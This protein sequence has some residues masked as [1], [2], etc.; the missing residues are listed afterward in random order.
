MRAI[1]TLCM[2]FSLAVSVR[3]QTDQRTIT[4]YSETVP[5]E[6]QNEYIKVLVNGLRD[7]GFSLYSDRAIQLDRGE[8]KEVVKN[9]EGAIGLSFLQSQIGPGDVAAALLS[10]PGAFSNFREQREAQQGVIGDSAR[11]EI[12]EQE[13]LALRLWSHSTDTLVSTIEIAEID[14]FAG[15]KAMA[16]DDFSIAVIQELGASAVPMAFGEVMMGMQKGIA[17]AVVLPQSAFEGNFLDIVGDGTAILEYKIRTGVTIVSSKWWKDLTATE[18]NQLL[19]I[20][21][22]AEIAASEIVES[23]TEWKLAQSLELGI[24]TISWRTFP[25]KD[26]RRAVSASIERISRENAEPIL[27]LRDE[28]NEL[29]R[30]QDGNGSNNRRN[31]EERG[32][33]EPPARVFFASNRR[34]DEQERSL[35]AKFANAE[36]P[37]STIR[38]GELVP[39]GPGVIGETVEEVALVA[40]S[41][42]LEGDDCVSLI[43][44]ATHDSGGTLLTYVH[45]YRNSFEDAVRSG[46]AFSRDAECDGVVLVWTWPSGA[47]LASYQYDEES[48]TI[49][50]P[51][52]LSLIHKLVASSKVA[53]INFLAHSMGSR[54]VSKL[55]RDAWINRPS[56]VVV[57]A[58]DVT[59]PVLKQAVEAADSAEVSLLATEADRCP[60]GIP[61]V[62]P[63]TASRKSKAP[64]SPR[65]HGYNRSKRFRSF[66]VVE[67][68]AR[69][70]AARS[71]G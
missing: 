34:F 52:F 64:L 23:A 9:Q 58:A 11:D 13:I 61:N 39:P 71:S 63:S 60:M 38:C 1:L 12:N 47:A 19:T 22:D 51:S 40:G 42:I 48:V 33:N 44:T 43:A 53:Q 55:M 41:S 37:N 54:F 69:V 28:I 36:D 45:G 4:I 27:Q 20:L 26:V 67:P 56:A 10:T 46:L 30:R 7:A 16:G 29:R 68:Q 5:S 31:P 49:S 59:R 70:F 50:E 2:L 62:A 15:V 14:D 32:S 66:V 18:Q 24:Q 17:D 65:R 35:S 25:D 8:L 57:A 21:D 3:A 6:A